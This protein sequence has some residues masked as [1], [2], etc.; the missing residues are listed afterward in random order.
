SA[1]QTSPSATRAASPR[2]TPASGPTSPGSR[3]P[4]ESRRQPPLQP[5]P[6][7]QPKPSRTRTDARI[8]FLSTLRGNFLLTPSTPVSTLVVIPQAGIGFGYGDKT[9]QGPLI[10]ERFV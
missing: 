1:G 3:K 5:A 4:S 10:K 6:P 7:H 8:A 9:S 2:P